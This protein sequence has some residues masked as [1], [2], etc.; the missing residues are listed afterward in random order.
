MKD[1]GEVGADTATGP[2]PARD[3]VAI[4]APY[5]QPSNARAA[6]ELAVTVLPLVGLWIFMF[7]TVHVGIWLTLALAIP[8]AGFLLRLFMIQHDCGHGSFFRQR[9]LNDWVGRI[10]GVLTLTPYGFWSRAHAMHHASSGNLERR[11]H[12]DIATLT[13]DEY[14]ACSTWGKLRYRLYR[15]PLVMFG[16]G[17]AYLFFLQH[18]LPIG[19][20][21]QGWQPWLSTMGTNVAIVLLAAGVIWLAGLKAY[22]VAY[23]PVALIAA[24]IGVWLFYIQHQFEETS[25]DGTETWNWHEAALRGSSHFDL[26]WL[27]RWFTAN[28]GIHHVHHLASRIPFYRLQNVLRDHPELR[29][30]SR[31]TLWQSFGCLRLS[32]WDETQRRLVS[33]RD[34]RSAT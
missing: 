17:P 24:S 32:L 16:L 8:A 23:L 28:I 21:R 12:G 14:K 29:D 25:W 22:L 34:A 6:L 31:M 7:A 18:R 30:V 5:R 4:L 33:F 3:W 27:L 1:H 11:G 15:Q 19:F 20:M 2:R 9:H 10:I 13:V 26:P